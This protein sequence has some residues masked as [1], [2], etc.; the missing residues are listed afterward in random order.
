MV[1]LVEVAGPASVSV[2]VWGGADKSATVSFHQN[3][4]SNSRK[5]KYI[6]HNVSCTLKTHHRVATVDLRRK[7]K[8]EIKW[9][10]SEAHMEWQLVYSDV[11][12][13]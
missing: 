5:S 8:Y 3:T 7:M 1:E 13:A 2:D 9:K 12:L 6:I 4:Q 11:S 10:W